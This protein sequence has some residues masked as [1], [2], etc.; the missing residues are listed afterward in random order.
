F[1]ASQFAAEPLYSRDDLGTLAAER[2]FDLIWCGSLFTHLDRDRWPELLGFFADHLSEHGVLVFTTH[3][4]QP[5]QWMLNGFADYGLRPDE[6]DA[7]LCGYAKDGFG[8]VWPS[9]QTIGLSLSSLAFVCGQ[10]ERWPSLK[11]IGVEEA[12]WSGHHDVFSC[13]RLRAP[14]PTRDGL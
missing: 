14:Y 6:R 2:R 11:L 7:L 13:Q 10:I 1:C 4:R 9:N 3:G 5:I 12:A 8:Y